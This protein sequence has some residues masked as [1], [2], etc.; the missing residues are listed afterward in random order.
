M[1]DPNNIPNVYPII[2]ENGELFYVINSTGEQLPLLPDN[3]SYTPEE[4]IGNPEGTQD[5]LR[6][7]FSGLPEVE[8]GKLYVGTIVYGDGEYPQPVYPNAVSEIGEDG[9]AEFSIRRFFS[10]DINDPSRDFDLTQRVIVGE[11]TFGYRVLNAEGIPLYE[12]K[13]G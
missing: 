10:E 11:A 5:G 9:T 13:L 4:F 12:G 7:D 3:Q 6:F 8:G 1:A 2:E